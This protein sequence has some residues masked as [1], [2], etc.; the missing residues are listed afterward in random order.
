M[1]SWLDNLS[2]TRKLGLGFGVVLI[3]TVILA[4]AG[5]NSL[6]SVIQR[7]NAMSQINRLG[8]ALTA[9]RIARLQYML[10][11][12]DEKA[13]AAVQRALDTYLRDHDKIHELFIS[14]ESTR[15]LE[16]QSAVIA[17]YQRS[18]NLM[19]E[20][21]KAT[22]QARLTM[23]DNALR[24]NDAIKTINAQV[25]QLPSDDES[26]FSQF[27][28]ITQTRED[29]Q[30]VRYQVR[31]YTGNPTADTER[32][33]MTQ[34]DDTQRA[35]AAFKAVFGADHPQLVTQIDS[36]LSAYR[37]AL[38]AFVKANADLVDVRGKLTE[39]AEEIVSY[40]ER[41]TQLQ[42]DRRDAESAQARGVQIVA[43]LLAVLFGVLAAW[44][45]TRQITRPLR[46]TLAA[47]ERIAAGDLAQ[48][49][50]V[51]RRDELGVLQQ[52]IQR[53]G[54]TLRELIGGIRDGV[55]QIASAAEELSAVT[56]QTA[57]GVN[58]QKIETDQVATA[59]HEMSATV[60]EVARN[61]EQASLA[62]SQADGEARE[63]DRVVIEAIAQIERLAQEVVR[64]S[65]AMGVLQTESDKI[66]SVV[67]VIKAVAE[68]TNL[69]A[70]NAAIEAARAGEA[71]RG[72]AVVADEVR[73]LAKR[74]QHSTE[75]IEVLVAGLQQGTQQVATIMQGS[76]AVTD[77]SVELSRKAGS[78]LENITGTVSNIQ[79][80]NQQIAAAA[81]QQ[82]AVAEEISRS[83]V[84]V[85]DI[86]EQTATAGE[87]IAKSSVELARLG[88]QLQA[89]VGHFRV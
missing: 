63:G 75:E 84:N 11:N 73:A 86:S 59:M 43:A 45:I 13:A 25:L 34:L 53:M 58:T 66:G 82:S 17:D 57:A 74:T 35:F 2:V 32:T 15:L 46:D 27:R 62:A 83:V 4:S 33:A 10:A 44:I 41:L 1:K 38:L 3:L 85:R 89:M 76:R 5:W 51:E 9:L 65:D 6:E 69:L 23:G 61:A 70:L 87:E 42:V 52:G 20:A 21:Y 72:F 54:A 8:D 60:Q 81:E 40:D 37:D 71:G 78:A 88:G 28:S 14:P 64:S 39:Q 26:R 56:E 36:A 22:Q 18:L 7:S 24:I 30:M 55:T 68:Q 67:D 47:V 79:S 29:W 50:V 31:G 80:M 77:T 12:G 49:L 48:S 16:Q 19:R